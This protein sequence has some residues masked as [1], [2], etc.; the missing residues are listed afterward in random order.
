MLNRMSTALFRPRLLAKYLADKFYYP[1]LFLVLMF[2]I[3]IAP[4]SLVLKNG[5]AIFPSEYDLIKEAIYSTSGEVNISNGEL[6]KTSGYMLKTEYFIYTFNEV[7]PSIMN[8][9]V[10]ITATDI[11]VYEYGIRV[12]KKNHNLDNLS[13][14]Q[15]ASEE[16]IFEFS[17]LV[18][19][20]MLEIEP[21]V[22]VLYVAYTLFDELIYTI[23]LILI[24]YVLGSF[25][26]PIVKKRF[27]LYLVIYSLCSFYLFNAISRLFDFEI[28]TYIGIIYSFVVYHMSLKTIV[29]IEVR[30]G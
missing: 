21:K 4:Y 9:V 12:S 11:E 1:I 22:K 29:K 14:N 23:A 17:Y 10:N 2:L 13:L 3:G 30:K 7:E 18:Y 15:N 8:T 26:N 5:H 20:F 25:I 24:F 27:R 28:L 19:N 6:S 16:D